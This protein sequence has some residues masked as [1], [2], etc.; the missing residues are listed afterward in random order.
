[1]SF[2]RNRKITLEA[3][4][5]ISL[6][7]TILSKLNIYVNLI[8]LA[9]LFVPFL[10]YCCLFCDPHLLLIKRYNQYKVLACST[11]F[12][13]LSLFC[14]ILFQLLTFIFLISSKTSFSQCVLGLPIGL[15]DM[16][17]HLLI[18]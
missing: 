12:F 2:L 10:S 9:Y 17:F 5:K 16:G 3:G 7:E 1:M 11:P 13:Q 14:A 15:L 6:S 8:L 4:T 18:S